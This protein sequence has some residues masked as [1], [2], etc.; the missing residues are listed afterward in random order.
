VRIQEEHVSNATS[1]MRPH[2]LDRIEKNPKGGLPATRVG[3]GKRA[4]KRGPKNRPTYRLWEYAT[5]RVRM[6][7]WCNSIKSVLLADRH[8]P[9]RPQTYKVLQSEKCPIDNAST[10]LTWWAGDAVPRPSHVR[11]AERLAP[12]SSRLIDLS[13]MGTPELRHLVA[14]DILNTKFRQS[15]RPSLHQRTQAQLLL[16]ALNEAWTPFLSVRTPVNGS[17]FALE[18]QIGPEGAKLLNPV[19]VDEARLQMINEGANLR[20]FA[21]PRAAVL[22]HSWLEPMSIF[23][24]LGALAN[25]SELRNPALLRMWACDFASAAIVVRSQ[26][27]LAGETEMRVW[28]MGRAGVIYALAVNTFWAP[29]RPRFDRMALELAESLDAAQALRIRDRLR[30]ARLAYYGAFATWGIPERAIRALNADTSKK[31]WDSAF[32]GARARI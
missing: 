15:G 1:H 14:L 2:V 32:G 5:W 4:V 6:R 9:P 27:E 3:A 10:W 13:E 20:R 28:R 16:T 30:G 29:V 24:F 25:F 19:E 31:T 23:R 22:E 18:R 21:L 7:A 26:L 12:G 17:R 11:A 8:E